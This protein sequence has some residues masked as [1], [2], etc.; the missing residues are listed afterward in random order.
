MRG[1]YYHIKN[2]S[3]KKIHWQ[4]C[5]TYIMY[6]II[7]QCIVKRNVLN[8]NLNVINRK[9]ILIKLLIHLFIVPTNNLIVGVYV[10]II[11]TYQLSWCNDITSYW[12]LSYIIIEV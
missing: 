5:S 4:N 9:Q 1:W 7:V 10:T 3:N 6:N 2:A 11:D 12:L 8:L